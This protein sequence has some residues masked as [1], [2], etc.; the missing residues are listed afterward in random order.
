MFAAQADKDDN[1]AAAA[2]SKQKKEARK[3]SFPTKIVDACHVVETQNDVRSPKT[4]TSWLKDLRL[5]KVLYSLAYFISNI[6]YASRTYFIEMPSIQ[7]LSCV[8]K[9]SFLGRI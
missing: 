5:Y 2:K 6:I 1:E 4:R 9:L 7:M 8:L 3:S